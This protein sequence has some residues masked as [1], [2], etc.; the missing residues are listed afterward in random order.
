MPSLNSKQNRQQ[1]KEKLQNT[2]FGNLWSAKFVI[3][4][5]GLKTFSE[6]IKNGT[7]DAKTVVSFAEKREFEL[8]HSES[9]RNLK[10][11]NLLWNSKFEAEK[12]PVLDELNTPPTKP[13][14]LTKFLFKESQDSV[15]K[16]KLDKES[17]EA[18]DELISCL[19]GPP[20][21]ESATPYLINLLFRYYA[22]THDFLSSDSCGIIHY[23]KLNLK[24]IELLRLL[25]CWELMKQKVDKLSQFI[26]DQ[27]KNKIVILYLPEE[28]AVLAKAANRIEFYETLLDSHS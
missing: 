2:P 4:H 3:L 17:T 18:I 27:R 24:M 1:E 14:T 6:M 23:V 13:A 9:P 16:P 26:E 28:K 7:I 12:I 25:E 11:S 20:A 8:L 5:T 10:I 19:K 21:D 22:Y 15:K